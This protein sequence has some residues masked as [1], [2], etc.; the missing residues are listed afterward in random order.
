MD[1]II[2]IIQCLF[3]NKY[4]EALVKYKNLKLSI[5]CLIILSKPFI[6]ILYKC[7]CN[8]A[9]CITEKH[10]ILT[11]YSDTFTNVE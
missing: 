8:Q 3:V 2:V 5:Y 10:L 7:K 9:D 6:H 11:T 1:K 4:T